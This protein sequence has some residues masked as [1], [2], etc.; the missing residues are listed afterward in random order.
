MRFSENRSVGKWERIAIFFVGGFN[1]CYFR[2]SKQQKVQYS[3]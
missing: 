1:F 2:E 3:M